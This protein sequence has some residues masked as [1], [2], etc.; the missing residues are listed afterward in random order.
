VVAILEQ[1]FRDEWGRV[2]ATLIGLLGDFELAEEAAQDAFAAAAE[3]WPRDG[4]PASPRAWLVTT[5]RNRAVDRIRRE[6]TLAAKTRLL[7][8]ASATDHAMEQTTIP[9][10]R[11]ELIFTCCH[12]AL[13][14]DAQVALTLRTLGGLTTEEIA[15][16]FLV[17]EPTMAK[18]LVRAK[19]KIAAAGIPFRVP[20]A[21]LLP[22]RLA[23]VLAVV[24][25]I[26]NEGYGGR[27]DLAAEAIRLGRALAELMPDEAEVHALLALMLMNDGR[28][29]ARFADDAVVLLRD[30]D[31]SLWDGAQIEQGRAELERALA[32]GGRGSYVLQAAIASLHL[33]EP[34]DWAQLAV[35]YGELARM[36]GS[37]VVELNHAAALA[38]TGEVEA[39]LAITDRLDLDGYHYLHA[40][41]AELL[42]RLG[43][44]ADARAAYLRALELV[45]S[46]PERRFLEQRLAALPAG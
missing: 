33:D 21:Q 23:A 34:P 19:H 13:A 27:G 4:T 26:F 2:L 16:A 20:P 30:Q 36:T 6:R 7:G 43:R 46:E 31:R 25:L 18:R 22:D 11:L 3:H 1:T 17:P 32:L 29:D 45:R 8:V 41:R 24:Y 15:R 28:R 35:L 42:R 10:E 39:A 9:D 44:A 12:P 14:L 5:A 38:E 37:P 40:T